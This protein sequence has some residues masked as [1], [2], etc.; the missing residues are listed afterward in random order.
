LTRK[1]YRPIENISASILKVPC[2]VALLS[3]SFLASAL[4]S[5]AATVLI[6]NDA[7]GAGRGYMQRYASIRDSGEDVVG[8]IGDSPRRSRLGAVPDVLPGAPERP[9]RKVAVQKLDALTLPWNSGAMSARNTF[10]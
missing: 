1:G 5:T 6:A 10:E 2:C 9:S 4:S 7:G 8:D 3:A